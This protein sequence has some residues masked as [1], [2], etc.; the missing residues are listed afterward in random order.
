MKKHIMRKK[1]E[2]SPLPKR[3]L[4]IG[5]RASLLFSLLSFTDRTEKTSFSVATHA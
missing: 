1:G 2:P 4:M 5:K 3:D